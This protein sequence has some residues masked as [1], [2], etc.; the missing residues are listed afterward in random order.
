MVCE[1]M[2]RKEVLR[3]YLIREIKF[4]MTGISGE[5]TSG[6]SW[7]QLPG[8]LVQLSVREETGQIWGVNHHNAIYLWTNGNSYSGFYYV[9]PLRSFNRI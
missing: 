7:H 2:F 6:A 8:S 3:S 4:I 1:N 5:S 9:S